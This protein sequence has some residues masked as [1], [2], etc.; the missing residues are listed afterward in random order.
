MRWPMFV[1]FAAVCTIGRTA[2][3]QVAAKKPEAPPVNFV[4]PD[5]LAAKACKSFTE[6][7]DAGDQTLSLRVPASANGIDLACF[8]QPDD[9]FFIIAL[10]G[11]SFA[12]THL[13]PRSGKKVPD[14]AATS[15]IVGFVGA[16]VNGINDPESIPIH[17]FSGD[18]TYM[19][20]E[21]FFSATRIDGKNVSNDD[22][23]GFSIDPQQILVGVRYKNRLDNTID[24]RLAI[25]RSTGRFSE[26]YTEQTAKIP[27]SD[28]SGRCVSIRQTP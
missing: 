15:A 5:P 2:D 3:A 24:Y 18:W 23:T 12:N 1:L 22:S 21:L 28:R 25:Q 8:R 6:L 4:C 17:M 10:N 16:F 13:D 20:G 9:E 27:F 11:P 19:L 14:D 26:R 7:R